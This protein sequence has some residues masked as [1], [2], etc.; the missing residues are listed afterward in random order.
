MIWGALLDGVARTVCAD[1]QKRRLLVLATL[2]VCEAKLVAPAVLQILVGHWQHQLAYRRTFMCV[3]DRTYTW[4]RS[5]YVG[6]KV[7]R[8]RKWLT[9][10]VR[11]ELLGLCVLAP[12]MSCRLDTP[13]SEFLVATDA[14]IRKGAVVTSRLSSPSQAAFLWRAS[15]QPVSKMTFVPTLECN[16][17]DDKFVLRVPPQI[18]EALNAFVCSSQ[19]RAASSY[20]FKSEAHINRQEMLAW[21]SGLRFVVRHKLARGRRVVCAIDSMVSVNVIKKGRSSSRQLNA[22]LQRALALQVIHGIDVLPLWIPSEVNPADD[23]TRKAK[24]RRAVPLDPSMERLLMEAMEGTE[25]AATVMQR[26]WLDEG[27]TT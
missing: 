1:P 6:E 20:T 11:D 7:S 25:W 14:T 19:F 18:N 24:L 21:L 15:D 23:P 10:Q 26:Q 9:R 5:S 22:V 3:L 27:V 13:M 16:R 12:L 4:L 8:K 17:D 2:A